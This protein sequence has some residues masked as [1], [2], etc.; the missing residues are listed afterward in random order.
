MS[1]GRR[2]IILC[3]QLRAEDAGSSPATP[4]KLNPTTMVKVKI[5]KTPL[6]PE[7][8][9]KGSAGCD[10]INNGP[11]KLLL[12]L[13]RAYFP[14][15]VYIQLPEG[16]E[17]QVRCRSGLNRKHGIICPTGTIDADYRGEIG[18]ILY[19]LSREPYTIQPYERIAQLVISPVVQAEW[20]EVDSL[21]ETERGEGGF[22]STGK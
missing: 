2:Q 14:T 13:D 4:P 12:P 8:Q 22:G 16:Y 9:T 6:L 7:Y 15:G 20:E 5:K 10:L 11:A 21:D 1:I 17:A 19:N 3:K 18:V